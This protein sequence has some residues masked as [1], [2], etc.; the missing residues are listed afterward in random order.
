LLLAAMTKSLD[1]LLLHING[2]YSRPTEIERIWEYVQRNEVP[3][4]WK[5]LAFST[6]CRTFADFLF[7]VVQ[8]VRFWQDLIHHEAHVPAVWITAFY[9]PVAFLNSLI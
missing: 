7:E 2:D 9:D 4:E 3:S 6:A 1:D 5:R 8:R